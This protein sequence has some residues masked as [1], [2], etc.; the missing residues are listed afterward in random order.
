[1]QSFMQSMRE[2]RPDTLGGLNVEAMED[3]RE[4]TRTFIDG[5]KESITGL[6]ASNVLKFLLEGESSCV[7]RPSGTEPKLKLYLSVTG[8][9]REKADNQEKQI[10]KNIEALLEN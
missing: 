2:N 8:N 10:V 9:D 5:R 3:Y 1:M 7:V 6:P 4:Q